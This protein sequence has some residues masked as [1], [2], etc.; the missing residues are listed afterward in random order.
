[1]RFLVDAQL[2]PALAQW[3]RAKGATAE[4]V[5]EIGLLEASDREILDAAVERGAVIIT[6][7]RDFI[8]LAMA[9]EILRVSPVVVVW[10]RIGN[11]GNASLTA[12]L[13]AVWEH[14]SDDLEGGA[15]VV[16]VGRP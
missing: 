2:P 7:D 4:H 14:V 5:A 6:K 3:L 13:E 12:R 1:M 11:V 15:R 10:I 8:A 16:E 9:R